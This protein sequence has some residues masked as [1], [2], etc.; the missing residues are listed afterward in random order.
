[1]SKLRFSV[2]GAAIAFLLTGACRVPRQPA[3][4]T[5]P[6]EPQPQGVVLPAPSTVPRYAIRTDDPDEI[7]LL[8]QRLKLSEV[9][10]ARGV[11]YFVA[12][13][14]QLRQLRELG[15]QVTQLDPETVDYRI[16][17]VQRRGSEESLREAGVSVITREP[18]YWIVSGTLAQ[19]RGLDA[20]GRDEPRPRLIR[21]V[22]LSALDV[23]RIANLQVDIFTVADTTGRYTVLGAAL[24]MQIDRLREAG[25]TV[26][27]LPKP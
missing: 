5:P 9:R 22:V 18:G 15:Y 25:F 19:L 14:G 20:L 26:V 1:M 7:A 21:I 27:L 17:R 13:D 4:T 24:D 16:L 10:A 12:D 2:A 23:Q 8:T 11:V 6:R 3:E